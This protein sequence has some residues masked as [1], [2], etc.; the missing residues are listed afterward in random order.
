MRYTCYQGSPTLHADVGGPAKQI[1]R[2]AVTPNQRTQ[3]GVQRVPGYN[4]QKMLKHPCP[5]PV[6]TK[7]S[8]LSLHFQGGCHQA[9][10]LPLSTRVLSSTHELT[11][12]AGPRPLSC[13]PLTLAPSTSP[14]WLPH[15]RWPSAVHLQVRSPKSSVPQSN[16]HSRLPA[17]TPHGVSGHTIQHVHVELILRA[18]SSVPSVS[19]RTSIALSCSRRVQG[20]FLS[21]A[22]T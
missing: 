15:N 12:R 1:K 5:H 13:H 8:L 2:T 7:S 11:C 20:V 18:A 22:F 17:A 21:H 10:S 14:L 3:T 6:I 4:A 9:A 19:S 16:L